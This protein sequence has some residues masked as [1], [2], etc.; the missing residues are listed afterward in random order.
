[1]KTDEN[2]TLSQIATMM[3]PFNEPTFAE[4]FQSGLSVEFAKYNIKSTELASVSAI[5][6]V[7]NQQELEIAKS[8]VLD[9]GSWIKMI[10]ADH[11]KLKTPFLE[12]T[13][14]L[15]AEKKKIEESFSQS[16]STIE[17]KITF[18]ETIEKRR[19]A[20]E[21]AEKL[22]E[23]EKQDAL[24]LADT[25]KINNIVSNVKAFLYGGTVNNSK[26]S[27]QKTGC[28]T[29]AEVEKVEEGIKKS[30]PGPAEFR[31]ECSQVYQ[32]S[33]RLIGEMIVARKQSLLTTAGNVISDEEA[34]VLADTNT[35][36]VDQA[37]RLNA[38]TIAIERLAE[39]NEKGMR[40][41]IEYEVFDVSRVPREFLMIDESK[42]NKYKIDNREKIL[43]ALKDNKAGGHTFI[44]G[45]RFSV[46]MKSIVR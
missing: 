30:L 12:V 39:V 31:E 42:L 2:K 19:I 38:G 16:K 11:K 26:G 17:T 23:K 22:R 4:N 43:E 14:I 21:L 37:R 10:V 25:A 18:Y 5:I 32:E 46:D 20:E 36:V 35:I 45:I 44:D 24:I 41:T 8:R 7:N 34:S 28:F 9:A 6:T 40:R 27:F 33:M 13:R 3:I 15:D 29:I 1:M